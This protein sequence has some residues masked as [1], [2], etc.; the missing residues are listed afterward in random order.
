MHAK[1][2]KLVDADAS[3]AKASTKRIA[4]SVEVIQGHAF[5]DH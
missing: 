5:L 1:H 4:P 3:G 2:G